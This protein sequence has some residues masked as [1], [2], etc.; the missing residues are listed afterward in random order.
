MAKQRWT[1]RVGLGHRTPGY[2]FTIAARDEAGSHA[3][4]ELC[5][6]GL[7]EV[8]DTVAQSA[9]HIKSFFTM[10]RLELAFYLGALN[11]H[12]RLSR[13]GE[14]TCF[15]EPVA[16]G[17]EAISAR[18]M[19]DVCLTL[20]IDDPAVGNDIDA[21][22]KRLVVITGANQGGKTT[23]LRGL[24]LAQIMM[25]SGLFVGGRSFRAA[26]CTGA[27]THFKREEDTTMTSGKLDEELAR[28]SQIADQITPHSLLLSNESFAST[29]EREGSEIARH[30]IRA[31]IDN[32][33]TVVLV[34]HMY[35]LAHHLHAEGPDSRLFL[36][37][38]REPDGR[39]TYR[40][41][42]GEPLPTSYGQDSYRR[43][44]GVPDGEGRTPA[45]PGFTGH[46]DSV[47][48][49]A[50]RSREDRL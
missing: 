48:M 18:G 41:L 10:L 26:V 47:G 35:D 34:T 27:F 38:E 29:N 14:P 4:T 28:M 1:E 6:R 46:D 21:D 50:E 17:S 22:G 20:T 36:R 12:E 30:I 5:A 39:R 25:P 32:N 13:K 15:P 31:L 23:M 8:A 24:G 16:A 42:P 3:L 33:I 7:N 45:T 49:V 43:V 2:S 40:V 11:L 44:F 19:Y 9:G 37:A